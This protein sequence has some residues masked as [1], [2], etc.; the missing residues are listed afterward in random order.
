M[1]IIGWLQISLLFLAVLV[2]IKPLGLYMAR[3]FSGEKTFLSPVLGPVER[4]LYRLSGIDPAK[5]QSWLAYTIAMLAFSLVGVASLYAILRLQAYLPLNPQGFPA[6]PSD[7][8]FNTAVSF[9]TN[10][11][12][13]NYAGEATMSHFSQMAGLTVHNFL[14]AATGMALAIAFTRALARS[15]VATLGN[16]WVDMTRATLYV[17]LPLAVVVT[18]IFVAMGL[19]QTLEASATATT[20]EGAQ[21]VISLGP[22]AS[23]E[24]IKQLGTNG[25]GFFN[26]NAAHPFENPTAWSDLLNIFAMLSISAALVYT[27]G[28]MVGNRRQGWALI[29]AM[30]VLLIAGVAVVYWA[31]SQGN[32][33]LTT[34]GLDPAQGNMEGKEVRFGQSATALYAAVTTGLSDGGVNGMLGSFTGLGGLVPMFL[35]QLG[36]VLPGGVGSGLY[37]ILVFALLSVFVAGL[38]VGRTPEFLGKK[39]ESREMKFAMLAVLILPLVILGFTAI[40]AML[41]VAV[42]AIGTPGPHGLSEILYA[43]TSAVGNNGSAFGGLSGN[44]LW[45]NTTLGIAMLL[46]RFAYVVPVMAIA[47]SLAAKV[48]TPASAGTFPT[49]G[50][51]FVGLLVGI[52]IILGGLQFFPALALGPIVEHFAMLAGQT[53]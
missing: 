13:Q 49:D 31:E 38:M 47:G 28:Q 30:A 3:V 27:F 14:S 4:G 48:K 35:I 46:G 50:P 29:T 37:G 34:L 45:Y 6:V 2:A 11:N 7:L 17:L 5:E 44:T 16:F 26:V 42:A 25:G 41:P 8:A 15:R 22:V 20:L 23:Q 51:L 12:W 39:I 18:L 43:Y 53:F 24:A 40:S 10:T 36:E 33:I 9:V 1:T 32:P 21:Q 52:I 19:P